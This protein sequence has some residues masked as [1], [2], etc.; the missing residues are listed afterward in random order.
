MYYIMYTYMKVLKCVNAECQVYFPSCVSE[1]DKVMIHFR[2]HGIIIFCVI[3]MFF[4]MF[5]DALLF[6]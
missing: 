1:G 3:G 6:V 4:F 2:W 5:P